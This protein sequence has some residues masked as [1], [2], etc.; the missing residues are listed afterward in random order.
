MPTEDY[1]EL[2]SLLWR[3][4]NIAVLFDDR[5]L[6][7]SIDKYIGVDDVSWIPEIED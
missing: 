4:R 7:E 3:C 6:A 1:E 2:L 5:E